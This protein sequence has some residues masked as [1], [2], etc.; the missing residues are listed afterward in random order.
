MPAACD[1]RKVPRLPTSR[2]CRLADEPL[3]GRKCPSCGL[4]SHRDTTNGQFRSTTAHPVTAPPVA[5]RQI[6]AVH[7]DGT[8]VE[9][10]AIGHVAAVTDILRRGARTVTV[11]H[12]DGTVVRYEPLEEDGA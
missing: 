9:W 4:R 7:T 3:R 12:E 1:N 10:P 2:P 11:E 6:R 8:T 5:P